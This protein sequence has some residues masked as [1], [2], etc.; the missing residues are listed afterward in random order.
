MKNKERNEDVHHILNEDDK[1]DDSCPTTGVCS[2]IEGDEVKLS[3]VEDV[4]KEKQQ[5]GNEDDRVVDDSDTTILD[6]VT[7]GKGVK[8]IENDNVLVD[9]VLNEMIKCSFEVQKSA[10][11]VVDSQHKIEDIFKQDEQIQSAEG[12]SIPDLDDVKLDIYNGPDL[13]SPYEYLH[14][15]VKKPVSDVEKIVADTLFAMIGS[16]F[17][18]GLGLNHLEM[19]TLTLTLMVSAYVI[20][21]WAE[22]LNIL[23]IYKD[24]SLPLRYFFKIMIP[25]YY[26][27]KDTDDEKLAVFIKKMKESFNEDEKLMSLQNFE[28]VF[29]SVCHEDH[30]YLICVD[31]NKGSIHLIDNSSTGTDHKNHKYKGIPQA[32]VGKVFVQYLYYVKCP[33]AK[34]IEKAKIK[35]MK[36]SWRTTRNST[37]CGVFT[38]LHMESYIGA[39]GEWKCGRAKESKKQNEQLNSPRSKFAAKIILSEFNLLMEKFMQL[40]QAFEQKTEEERKKTIDDAIANRD[41]LIN[42]LKKCG[43][44]KDNCELNYNLQPKWKQYGTLM[45]QTEN[46]M[47]INI[48]A[49]YNIL[50]QNQRDVN[51]AM[52]SKKKTVVVTSDPLAL[53]AEKTNVSKRK[54]KVIISSN[55]EESGRDD[56]SELKKITALLAKAF[57]RRKFYSKPTNNNLRTSST[58]QSANKK[59]E[60]VK[61]NDKKEDKKAYEKKRDKSK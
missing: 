38:M 42:D 59:Q 16:K 13:R 60:F 20:D 18:S 27:G 53:V 49:L 32:I 28:M 5:I 23:E 52:G 6:S 19:E 43:Y 48:D 17:Q 21:V 51:D 47:D 44:K 46:L 7:E 55:S 41:H 8:F 22:L 1:V 57:N 34:A 33:K 31:F 24:E 11:V 29:F 9:D 58:S 39:E 15:D 14:V 10:E 3:K 56:F 26:I 50:K 4:E 2:V 36:I 37:D 30:I 61:T 25:V 40:V 12:C 45:R 35:R 54:E